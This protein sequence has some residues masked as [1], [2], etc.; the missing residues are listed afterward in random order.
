MDS[1]F[2]DSMALSALVLAV[3]DEK[4]K[5]MERKQAGDSE[6]TS[7]S[8]AEETTKTERTDKDDDEQQPTRHKKF[9]RKVKVAGNDD[10]LKQ[11]FS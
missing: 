9:E 3:L 5:K 4:R 10:F 8:K 2:R 6:A 7:E 1:W 11:I